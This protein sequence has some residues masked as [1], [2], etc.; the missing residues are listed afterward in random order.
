MEQ[1]IINLTKKTIWL[2]MAQI[3]INERYKNGDFKVPVHLAMGHEAVAVAVDAVMRQGDVLLLTHRNAH[4]NLA[5]QGT[6]KEELDEYYLRDGGLAQGRLGS[7]NLNNP[8]KGIPYA[9]SILG[10]D[11]PVACGYAIGNKAKGVKAATY[12]TTGDGAM[13]EGAFYESL[14]LMKSYDLATVLIIENN[15]WSLATRID[16]R[17]AQISVERLVS[18]LDI[19]YVCLDSNDVVDYARQFEAIRTRAVENN[20]PIVVEVKLTTLGYWYMTNEQHPDGK[21]INYHCGPAPEVEQSIS[22]VY[23]IIEDS[24]ADPLYV[25]TR[26]FTKEQLIEFSDEMLFELKAELA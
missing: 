9:S 22:G 23:P 21:F 19:E 4:Y 18:G 7:M 20:L 8:G 3:L 2:R 24:E 26:H 15:D 10:N 1:A 13:E 14:L 17:R 25:L 5:R 11:M 6:L 16:E 12:V